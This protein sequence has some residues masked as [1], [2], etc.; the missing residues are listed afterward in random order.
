MAIVGKW[1]YKQ[2]DEIG[3]YTVF[4]QSMTKPDVKMRPPEVLWKFN[5]AVENILKGL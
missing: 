1:C 5:L 4:E 2:D 3:A